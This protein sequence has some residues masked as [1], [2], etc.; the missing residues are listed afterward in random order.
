MSPKEDM[1]DQ[2]NVSKDSSSSN[3]GMNCSRIYG[4]NDSDRNGFCIRLFIKLGAILSIIPL[5][6]L[7]IS[8]DEDKTKICDK[9][10]SR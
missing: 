3:G 10:S 6:Y 8:E 5:I 9:K 4:N 2:R 1:G 7:E